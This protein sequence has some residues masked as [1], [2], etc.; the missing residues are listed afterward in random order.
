MVAD[1]R[2]QRDGDKA[3]L[4][5]DIGTN[6][7]ILLILPGGQILGCSTAAGPAFEGGHITFGSPP[8]NGA[9]SNLEV[10]D[11]SIGFNIIGDKK[12][13][14]GL[15]GAAIIDLV[16]GL[17]EHGTVNSKGNLI[18]GGDFSS[19][20]QHNSSGQPEFIVNEVEG[21]PDKLVFTQE[22]VRQVQLAKGAICAGIKTLMEQGG[23]GPERIKEVQLAGAFGIYVNTKNVQTIGLLPKL[24]EAEIISLGNAAG[25]G[26]VMA[27][28]SRSSFNRFHELAKKIEY[29][30]LA[31]DKSFN[32]YF[33][34]S[35]GF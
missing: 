10:N 22:D 11:D 27:A 20:I 28:V 17:L 4:V 19:R 6:G 8:V 31:T 26:A 34:D 1:A 14:Q 30:E 32:Q 25:A 24:P 21:N 12:I 2:F 18:P 13:P 29:I 5:I 9:V 33:I 3:V 7:E 23:I 15:T 35:M 16:A